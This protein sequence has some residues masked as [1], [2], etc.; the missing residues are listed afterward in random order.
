MKKELP[1]EDKRILMLLQEN[2]DEAVREIHTRYGGYLSKTVHSILRNDQDTEECVNDVLMQL[3]SISL[4]ENISYFKAYLVKMARNRA[5]TV[6]RSRKRQKRGGN[7]EL[8]SFEELSDCI[9]EA[10]DKSFDEDSNGLKE[11]FDSFLLGLSKNDRILFM[12]RY[13]MS[14]SV[15]EIAKQ[16]GKSERYIS[17]RLCVLRKRLKS[18]LERD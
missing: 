4:P 1:P 14:L 16:I 8:V 17:K 3:W 10:G 15:S 12:K 6:L 7:I 13:W 11:Q 18:H 2:R 5:L 9:P